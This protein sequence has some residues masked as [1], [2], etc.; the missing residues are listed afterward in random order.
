MENKFYFITH[1][2]RDPYFNLASEEYLLKQTD[3]YYFYLWINAPAVIV[4]VN[5]N[6]FEEV[7]LS[8]VKENDIKVVR[9][10]TGGGA[11]YHDSGNL[12]YT[13]IAPYDEQQEN[14]K[15]FTAPVIEY[16]NSIGVNAEFSGRNDITVDGKKISGNAQTVFG[17]RI[18]HHG[19]LLFNTDPNALTKSLNPNKLKTQSKGIKSI[20][21]RV[22]NIS[23]RMQ[24]SITIE[25][26]KQGLTQKF[27][28]FCEPYS[29]SQN[30]LEKIE[31][32]V[33]EKYSTYEWNFSRSPLSKSV[34]EKKFDFGIV[35][36]HFDIISGLIK[37]PMITGDF[38]SLKP[39][40]LLEKQLEN[41]PFSEQG[42][43][44]AL[45]DVGEYISGANT[46]ELVSAIIE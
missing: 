45:K 17:K 32:L 46:D 11:V 36:I 9:R 21:A 23:E 33:R 29:F 8:Y 4:G 5:Q 2:N 1:D 42:L 7:N 25:Q 16:L 12:C 26:F 35:N 39:I 41:A 3:G 10:L 28:S 13:V 6:A 38:F 31:K 20:R 15:I 43:L 19:T 30:D 14:Y 24:N 37:N 27:L 34:F 18:M 44:K 22:T 40:E